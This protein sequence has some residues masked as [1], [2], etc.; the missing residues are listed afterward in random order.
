[1]VLITKQK[2]I[3]ESGY[4]LGAVCA[5]CRYRGAP[6]VRDDRDFRCHRLEGCPGVVALG[7]CDHWE[8]EGQRNDR[9]EKVGG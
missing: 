8:Q 9:C 5:V 6:M 7:V 4:R 2:K 1:M 3:E